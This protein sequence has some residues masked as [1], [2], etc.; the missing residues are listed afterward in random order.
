[1]NIPAYVAY[2]R[3]KWRL[4]W[5]VEMAPQLT[6]TSAPTMPPRPGPPFA[7]PR[8]HEPAASDLCR[9]SQ[10]AISNIAPPLRSSRGSASVERARRQLLTRKLLPSES[11]WRGH[12]GVDRRSGSGDLRK[13][14]ARRRVT[15]SATPTAITGTCGSERCPRN[16]VAMARPAPVSAAHQPAQQARCQPSQAPMAAHGR[17]PPAPTPPARTNGSR[18][19]PPTAQAAA[20]REPGGHLAP[21]Q[22]GHGRRPDQEEHRGRGEPLG[23]H[24]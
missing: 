19:K 12:R 20:D 4:A 22:I 1:M 16:Q 10:G 8:P 15:A 9:A 14:P 23:Y 7:Q 21:A 24:G 13:R 18:S 11:R 3:P 6:S 17:A 2:P 5:K